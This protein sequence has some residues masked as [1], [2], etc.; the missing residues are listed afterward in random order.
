MILDNDGLPSDV[1]DG[2][3]SLDD[4]TFLVINSTSLPSGYI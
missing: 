4:Y 1:F 2:L 3:S